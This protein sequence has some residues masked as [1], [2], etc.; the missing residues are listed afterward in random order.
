MMVV[1]G[2]SDV[3]AEV[4]G[5]LVRSIVLIRQG[6]IRGT[7]N[8]VRETAAHDLCCTSRCGELEV[9]VE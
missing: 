4:S 3:E 6:L 2:C 9:C 1:V 8:S 7:E 5:T